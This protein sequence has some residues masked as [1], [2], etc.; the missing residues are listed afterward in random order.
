MWVARERQAS[1]GRMAAVA[2][3]F[4]GAGSRNER[5]DER[6]DERRNERRNEGARSLMKAALPPVSGVCAYA[7]GRLK[8]DKF[9]QELEPKEEAAFPR[10]AHQAFACA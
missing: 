3:S 4:A 2:E 1:L 6:R 8:T 7:Q 5:R 10:V 9:P